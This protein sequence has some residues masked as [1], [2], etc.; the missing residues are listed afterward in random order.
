MKHKVRG[1]RL[2]TAAP[3][4]LGS[5]WVLGTDEALHRVVFDPTYD[6][7]LWIDGETG[8]LV[9]SGPVEPD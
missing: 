5:F 8:K 2:T 7:E 9:I 4:I 3:P 6:G 1:Y